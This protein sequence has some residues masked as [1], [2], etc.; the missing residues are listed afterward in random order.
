V[1]VGGAALFEVDRRVLI[2]TGNPNFVPTLIVLGAAVVPVAFV[3]FVY[4][5]RLRY[6]I[7]VGTLILIAVVG[8]V[9]GT[10]VAGT[11]EFDTLRR[12]GVLPMVAVGLIEE[13]SKLIVPLLV[14]LFTRHRSPA[15]GL[16]IGV[17]SGAGFAALETMGYAFVA[18]IVSHGSIATVDGILVLRGV[19]SPAGHMAWTGLTCAALW[20]AASD[21]WSRR[22][23]VYLVLTFIAAVALHAAWDSSRSLPG[24]AVVA[25]L[26]IGLLAVITHRLAVRSRQARGAA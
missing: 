21:G 13:S 14:L 11:L 16:L 4:E 15:D 5:R 8:G 3:S 6:D 19:L 12:L 23:V 1:L 10:V 26:S 9:I 22:S 24:Y 25:V 18:L 17:A 20:Q 7:S 2:D